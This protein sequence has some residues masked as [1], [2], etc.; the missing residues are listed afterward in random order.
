MLLLLRRPHRNITSLYAFE[1]I[2]KPTT[3]A[4]RG[5]GGDG[6]AVGMTSY[7]RK[8]MK[9]SHSA[10]AGLLYCLPTASQLLKL[11]ALGSVTCRNSEQ[12]LLQALWPVATQ[13]R[14]CYR[15]CDLSQLRTRS[16][17]TN[18]L[19][20]FGRNLRWGM[21]R[22]KSVCL[23]HDNKKHADVQPCTEWG[24]KT[25]SLCPCG[26]KHTHTH[27]HTHLT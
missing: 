24:S 1:K 22:R 6:D 10:S 18:L 21:A 27:A 14:F 9:C 11:R 23:T 7:E 19:P 25:R 8:P 20:V 2:W 26:R 4:K 16:A 15:L 13:N 3:D 17:T 5:R 12:V